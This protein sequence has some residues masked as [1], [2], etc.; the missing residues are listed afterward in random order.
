[1]AGASARTKRVVVTGL[2]C[3]T[4]LGGNYASTLEAAWAGRSGAGAITHF[5]PSEFSCRIAAE[6]TEPLA[7]DILAARDLRRTNR[8]VLFALEATAEALADSGLEIDDG[9]RNR[10]GVAIGSGI[11]GLGTILENDAILREKGPR[12]VSPFTIPMGI[13]NM[14]SGMISVHYSIRGPNICHVSACA[15]GA[16]AIGEAAKL[17]ERGQADV[18]IVGG[19][20]A[21]ILGVTVAGF[22]SMKALSTR[23]DD[24]ERA[25]R[26][27]D[28][29]R[30]GFVVGEGAGVL[31]I[32]SLEHAQARG[33][34]IRAEVM[35]YGATADA[36]HAVAPDP[37]GEAASRCMDLALEDAGIRPEDVGYVNAH[38]TS[39]PA[40]DPAE[41]VALRRTFGDY[42]D[43]LPV[44]AT[45]SMTGHLLGAA[46]SV[47]AILSIGAME[48]GR[49]PPTINLDD[50]DPACALDHV[51]N[52]ARS[53]RVDVALSN[54]FGFGGTN[55][56]L[57]LGL[58]GL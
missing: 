51:A 34:S 55:A 27:F 14:S 6:Y 8:C 56:S 52:R 19:A 49:L 58:G 43:R 30:D 39:T 50:P 54:S 3:V 7:P 26:P 45:K 13:A 48:G 44:S 18:M 46:G 1:M 32:E 35:G 2:G 47:E 20:E 31:V 16:H 9:N 53:V 12:R 24:P 57:V 38:A 25:S 17:I 11:G 37:A 29:G 15:S 5:D 36:T 4:P 33:A 21:P 23:N 22:A 42:L 10:I 28:R 41:V 40:G